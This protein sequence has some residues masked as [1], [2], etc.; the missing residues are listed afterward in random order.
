MHYSGITYR[1]PME[2]DTTLLQITMGCSYN[3]CAFCTMYRNVPFRMAPEEEIIED[4]KEVARTKPD[5]RRIFLLNG[6]PFV[7]AADKLLHIAE[8]VHQHLPK[9]ET[10]TCYCSIGDLKTKTFEEL[11][12][13]RKAGY[14]QLYIGLETGYEPAMRFIT[15]G[16][17]LADAERELERILKAG[18][19]YHALLMLGIA[20]KGNSEANAAATAKL[21]NKYKPKMV[22]L[23]TTSVSPGTPLEALR[24]SGEYVQ[25]T[26]REVVEEELML[27]R[28]LELDDD[29]FFHGSHPFNIIPVREYFAKKDDMILD[30]EMELMEYESEFLD[31]TWDRGRI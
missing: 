23:T 13:L 20:G 19:D 9:V 1:P 24:D 11:A 8:L 12:A 7:L 18:F 26:E 21:L 27:L 22:S 14:N 31:S 17:S 3:K 25:L 2:A 28:A 15:K 29:C 16:Y 6:D 4:L 5:I 10:L 30:I